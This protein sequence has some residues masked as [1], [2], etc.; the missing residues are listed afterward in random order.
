MFWENKDMARYKLNIQSVSRGYQTSFLV[1]FLIF[2]GNLYGV[3]FGENSE[4]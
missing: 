2:C 1:R 4:T 3:R